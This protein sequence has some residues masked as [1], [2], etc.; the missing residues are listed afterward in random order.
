MN[1]MI[2]RALPDGGI[3]FQRLLSDV[4]TGTGTTRTWRKG[5]ETPTEQDSGP[6]QICGVLVRTRMLTGQLFNQFIHV[7][8]S[9]I[10]WEF[11]NNSPRLNP[12]YLWNNKQSHDTL[13]YMRLEPSL[14][15]DLSVRAGKP[16]PR[17]NAFPVNSTS[18]RFLNQPIPS[19]L[20]PLVHNGPCVLFAGHFPDS[21]RVSC[22]SCPMFLWFLRNTA[23]RE[24]GFRLRWM[25][26]PSS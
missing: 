7:L 26:E 20:R 12:H 23:P 14:N 19:V 24:R 10:S 1:P 13:K 22:H 16:H 5:V 2:S 11:Q 21:N 9:R 4:L 8:S 3:R 6:C 17:L 18:A 25:T 15:S